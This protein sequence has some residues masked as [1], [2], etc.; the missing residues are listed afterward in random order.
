MNTEKNPLASALSNKIR[1]VKRAVI[2]KTS[3]VLSAPKRAYHGMKARQAQRD[4][5]VV[6]GANASKGAPSRDFKGN[7]LDAHKYRVMADV[8][9]DK[10]AKMGARHASTTK[11]Y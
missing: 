2:D 8:V 9:K 6:K 1:G 3:D 4:Y 11:S 10:Y 5:E 7:V